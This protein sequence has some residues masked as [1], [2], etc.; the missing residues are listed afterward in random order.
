[1]AAPV[2]DLVRAVKR[3]PTVSVGPIDLRVDEGD[4][5]A[6]LG[7][8]GGGKSTV[9][10]LAMGLLAPDE[11]E[12]RFRGEPIRRGDHA[13]RRRMG[14]VV[15]GGGLFPHLSCAANV[16]LVAREIGWD[17]TRIAARLG[18][19]AEL[20]RLPEDALSRYP[21][22]LSGGQAQ[23]VSLMRALML[24]PEVLLLDEPLGALDPVTRA[25]LQG[26]LRRA[27]EEVHKTVLLVTHDLAE[28]AFLARRTAILRDGRI[29][30]A[31][32]LDDLVRAPADAFVARFLRSARPTGAGEGAP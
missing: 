8:S 17:P 1:M 30:Q 3:Y 5:V 6:L 19:L 31:G 26:D 28:A 12:V 2:L 14:Y 13:L 29:V 7:P 4:A 25:E 32:T 16:T 10:R 20:A 21:G 24:D 22:E 27:I 9:L 15:Q 18:S 23:R 11:G